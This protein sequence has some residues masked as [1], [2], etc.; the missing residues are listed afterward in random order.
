MDGA[1]DTRRSFAIAW[2][3]RSVQPFSGIRM[4]RA[5][6]RSRGYRVIGSQLRKGVEEGVG[7]G[8][9]CVDLPGLQRIDWTPQYIGDH[10]R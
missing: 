5:S 8:D 1:A 3:L 7:R 2:G 4:Q 10:I 6:M 9:D